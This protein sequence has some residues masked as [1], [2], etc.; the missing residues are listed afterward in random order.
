MRSDIMHTIS[1]FLTKTEPRCLALSQT[2]LEALPPASEP[3]VLKQFYFGELDRTRR[4]RQKLQFFL[5]FV[6]VFF[7]GVRGEPQQRGIRATH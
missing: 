7:G 5:F 2:R 1:D 6:G 4:L 3:K